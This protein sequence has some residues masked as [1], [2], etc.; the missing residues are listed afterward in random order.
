MSSGV[1]KFYSHLTVAASNGGVWSSTSLT[2][3]GTVSSS[4][5]TGGPTSQAS[6]GTVL[7]DLSPEDQEYLTV[8]EEIQST[9]REHKDNGHA[10]GIFSRYNILKVLYPLWVFLLFFIGLI[11]IFFFFFFH[12]SRKCVID[13]CGSATVTDDVKWLMKTVVR[14]TSGCSSM[15]RLLFTPSFRRDSTNDTLTLAA[16][17]APV[18]NN[19]HKCIHFLMIY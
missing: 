15:D 11:F 5:A 2:T 19:R 17:L 14:A 3:T 12:R 8:E 18:N 6:S 1:E 9:I 13:D 10:G 7:I 16:C 4:A